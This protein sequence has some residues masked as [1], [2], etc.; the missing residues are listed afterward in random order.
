M[1]AIVHECNLCLKKNII[2]LITFDRKLHTLNYL[3][4]ICN[5]RYFVDFYV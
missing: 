3:I 5:A 2:N 1:H 4:V